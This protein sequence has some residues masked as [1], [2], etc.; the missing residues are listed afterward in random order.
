MAGGYT[1]YYYTYTAWDIIRPNDTPPGYAYLRHLR[2][3]F[4]GTATG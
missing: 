2:E 4:E 1:C 3:F